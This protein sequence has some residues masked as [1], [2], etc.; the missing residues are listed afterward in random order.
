MSG[1]S[2]DAAANPGFAKNVRAINNASFVEFHW[3]PATHDCTDMRLING[4]QFL[5]V[6]PAGELP[7]AHRVDMWPDDNGNLLV[8]GGVSSARYSDDNPLEF[9]SCDIWASGYVYCVARDHNGAVGW[10]YTYEAWNPSFAEGARSIDSASF[11]SFYVNQ[12]NQVCTR[13]VVSKGSRYLP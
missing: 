7:E 1:C 3:N 4:S 2:L 10:C 6:P 11:V 9:I 12:S 5:Q 8:F 13:I